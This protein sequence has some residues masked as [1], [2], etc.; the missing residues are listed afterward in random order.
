MDF[1][2]EQTLAANF[3]Q[4]LA[5]IPVTLGADLMFL[6]RAHIT[7]NGAEPCQ[8]SQECP[9]LPERQRRGARANPEWEFAL[10]GGAGG[11]RSADGFRRDLLE[12][13]GRQD[14]S[15]HGRQL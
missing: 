14:G 8:T 15:I 5:E 6:K 2:G 10:T 4:T 1:L 7:K 3:G 9:C 11:M 13:V 12:G